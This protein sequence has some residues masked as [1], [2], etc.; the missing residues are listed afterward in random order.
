MLPELTQEEFSLALDAVA[1]AVL[2]AAQATA[3]PVDAIELARALRLS[4]AWDDRQSGRGRTVRIGDFRG[5]RPRG[6][7]LLRPEPRR[8]RLHWA[9]AHEIGETCAVQV[10]DRLGVDPREAPSGAR[11]TVANQLAGRLL[12]PRAWFAR[13]AREHDWDVLRLKQRY[14]TASHELIARRMLDFPPR[15]AITV[16]DHGRLTL[17]QGNL[18]CRPGALV[19]AEIS[20]W[21]E[22]H[23]ESRSVVVEDLSCRVQVWPIHEPDWKR[24][25]LRTWWHTAEQDERF[26]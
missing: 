23:Q 5:G 8:E 10:F 12:L 11:E 14:A 24:E 15:I 22:A 1:A 4:V 26:D 9:I 21:R 3:P 18:S 13:D 20:G 2:D 16:F 6:S 7:I 25:I 17:R 19:P